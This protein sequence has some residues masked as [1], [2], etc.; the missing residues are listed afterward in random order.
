MLE[1]IAEEERLVAPYYRLVR[2]TYPPDLAV[3]LDALAEQQEALRQHIGSLP[4]TTLPGLQAKARVMM[5]WL[6]PDGEVPVDTYD[7]DA[8]FAWSLCRDLLNPGR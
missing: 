7:A 3:R 6:A 5:L 4:A 1:A 2:F 8:V